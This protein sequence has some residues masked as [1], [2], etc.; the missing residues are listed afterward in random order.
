MKI[1]HRSSESAPVTQVT[2]TPTSS[3][4]G[5]TTPPVNRPKPQ[6]SSNHSWLDFGGTF[7]LILGAVIIAI[8]LNFFVFSQY[9]VDGPSMQTTLQTGNRLI[10]YKI[11]RTWA[12]ITC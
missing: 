4:G 3:T 8:I 5:F 6:K 11:P 1:F 10:V 7:S 12:R 2:P 9:Q